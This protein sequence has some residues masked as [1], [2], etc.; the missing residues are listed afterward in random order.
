MEAGIEP[1]V[2]SKIERIEP[3]V[4][5]GNERKFFESVVKL[6]N[7]CDSLSQISYY[8]QS[9]A[10]Q[11]LTENLLSTINSHLHIVTHTL[12]ILFNSMDHTQRRDHVQS[13]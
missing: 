3:A 6:S 13:Y 5:S 4:L 2:P 8:T 9:H 10:E 11:K 1:A 12:S 7:L